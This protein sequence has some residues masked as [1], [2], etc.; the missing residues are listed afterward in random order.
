[1]ISCSSEFCSNSHVEL[2][3]KSFLMR[4]FL[5]SRTQQL[6]EDYCTVCYCK[7]SHCVHSLIKYNSKDCHRLKEPQKCLVSSMLSAIS[8]TRL[9]MGQ[10]L[11]SHSDSSKAVGIHSEV[12]A[13][14]K[15]DYGTTRIDVSLSTNISPDLRV[16]L[17]SPGAHRTETPEAK[18]TRVLAV[19][20]GFGV[21]QGRSRI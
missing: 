12:T 2:S 18:G 13:A 5:P 14:G 17:G 6:L 9:T 7:E 15:Q 19:I 21:K 20:T 8:R 10:L 11:C 1:M 4:V 3:P 16:F